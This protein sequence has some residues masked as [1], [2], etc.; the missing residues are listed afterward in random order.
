M[1][2]CSVSSY[3]ITNK[4][5]RLPTKLGNICL[6]PFP[7]SDPQFQYYT[8]CQDSWIV[9]FE[10]ISFNKNEPLD[11]GKFGVVYKGRFRGSLDVAVKKLKNDSKE[12]SEKKVKEFFSETS[13]MK[14]L[15]HPNLVQL[16][17]LVQDKKEGNL[18]IQEFVTNGSLKSYLTKIDKDDYDLTQLGKTEKCCN[19]A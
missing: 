13:T 1:V 14:R 3:C 7:H 16:F 19:L 10:E 8:E 12:I 17:A 6:I 15:N 11:E 5:E 4:E 2:T 9:P 18:I